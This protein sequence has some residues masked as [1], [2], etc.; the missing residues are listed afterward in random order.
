LTPK[1][2]DWVISINAGVDPLDAY[3]IA[4]QFRGGAGDITYELVLWN[5]EADPPAATEPAN[6]DAFV[7][8]L[9]DGSLTI[10]RQE[11]GGTETMHFRVTATD[12]D[13]DEQTRDGMVM[14][15][16]KPA[17]GEQVLEGSTGSGDGAF[18]TIGTDTS[19]RAEPGTETVCA[20]FGMCVY[21][22]NI[23]GSAVGEVH[24][25]D[26]GDATLKITAA[27][28]KDPSIVSATFD[29]L[30][31][32][33]TGLKATQ[34]DDATTN[35][36]AEATEVKV[37]VTDDGGLSATRTF[38]VTVDGAPMVA[39]DD[40]GNPVLRK[41]HFELDISD[42]DTEH[43]V[44]TD[45][46]KLF[47]DL[48]DNDELEFSTESSNEFL[49]EASIAENTNNLEVVAKNAT[50][51]TPVTIKV[52]ATENHSGRVG[53]PSSGEGGQKA[54]LSITVTVK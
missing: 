31:L 13:E 49:A 22:L 10:T 2:G 21:T 20:T 48:E 34:D 19:K 8:K 26:E 50:G 11:G 40:Q 45:V 12:A 47:N 27:E 37:T 29:K 9:E 25:L 1:R 43:I 35:E 16:E 42:T 18:V 38:K 28:P 41:T 14:S 24:F 6:T 54:E 44:I 5:P 46:S 30:K 4:D 17:P 36:A 32:T 51:S 33:L 15:N 53:A 23:D 52:I 3:S 39:T 7:L